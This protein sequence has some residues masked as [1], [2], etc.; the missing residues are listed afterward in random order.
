MQTFKIQ[1]ILIIIGLLTASPSIAA[2]KKNIFQDIWERI[3]RSQGQEPPRSVRGGIC[4]VVPGLNTVV[5]RDRPFFLWRD[6]AATIHL[7]QGNTVGSNQTPL[8]SRSV[9]PSQSFVSYDGEPLVAGLY[10]WEAISPL[11]VKNQT[12]FYVMDQAERQTLEKSLAKF[13]HIEGNDRI[14]QR[15]TVLEKEGLL[16]DTV[17]E[18]T[19]IEGDQAIVEKMQED[20]IKAVCE[21][22]KRRKNP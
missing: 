3:I 18:L 13:D 1:S 21:P 8:W 19:G 5:S 16:G 12:P 22:V 17:A 10:T 9:K 20:F 7:Y 11:G 2:E 15:M 14:L 6:T 4:Q